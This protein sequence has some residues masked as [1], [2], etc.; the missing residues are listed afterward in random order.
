MSTPT[1]GSLGHSTLVSLEATP[2]KMASFLSVVVLLLSIALRAA[3]TAAFQSSSKRLQMSSTWRLSPVGR[4]ICPSRTSLRSS[5]SAESTVSAPSAKEQS[6]GTKPIHQASRA[7]VV[8]ILLLLI[9]Q[10]AGCSLLTAAV[11]K[12]TYYDGASV[13]LAQEAVKVL[14]SGVVCPQ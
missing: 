11:R 1:P 5:S 8:A 2:F 6:G 4:R 3:P 13:A 7:A 14:N 9:F 10:N 12:R